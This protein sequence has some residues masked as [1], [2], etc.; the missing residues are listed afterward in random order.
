MSKS[1]YFIIVIV[2]PNPEWITQYI[3]DKIKSET[4]KQT[5]TNPEQQTADNLENLCFFNC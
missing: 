5:K 3:G 4:N 1:P 2:P